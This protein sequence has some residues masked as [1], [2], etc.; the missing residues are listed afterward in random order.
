LFNAAV[1]FYL[2]MYWKAGTTFGNT[3]YDCSN[4]R[5]TTIINGCMNCR[6]YAG[7]IISGY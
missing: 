7:R 5:E 6:R 3:L 2:V 1:T 4:W